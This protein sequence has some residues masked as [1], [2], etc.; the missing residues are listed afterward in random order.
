M[1]T[2]ILFHLVQKCVSHFTNVFVVKTCHV[3]FSIILVL[4]TILEGTEIKI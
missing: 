3:S 4:F 2:K 1:R